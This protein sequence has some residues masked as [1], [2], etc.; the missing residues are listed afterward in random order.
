MSDAVLFGM[1]DQ[2]DGKTVGD[3]VING[4]D[5]FVLAST[6]FRMG[7]YATLPHDHRLALEALKNSVYEHVISGPQVQALEYRGGYII[8]KLF[9]ALIDAPELIAGKPGYLIR[10]AGSDEKRLRALADYIAGMT[11]DYAERLY[12]KL[13]QPG[14]GSVFE[15]KVVSG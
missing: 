7:P 1:R 3:G 2:C 6:L 12:N 15:Y 10:E 4:F 11:D 9:E 14:A 8:L 5:M 13:F